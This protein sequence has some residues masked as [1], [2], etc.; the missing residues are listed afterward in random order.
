MKQRHQQRGFTLIEMMVGLGM[1]SVLAF[2]MASVSSSVLRDIAVEGRASNATQGLKGA[3]ELLS[4]EMRM[5]SSVSPYL[6]GTSAAAVTCSGAFNL[7]TTQL[8]FMVVQDESTASTSGLQPYY[9]GYRYDAATKRLLRGE[10]PGTT[11]SSC[12][13]PAGDPASSTYA[14]VLAEHIVQVDGDGDGTVDAAFT[15]SASTININLGVEIEGP[16]GVNLVQPVPISI[17]RR[18][19]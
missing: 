13:V 11:I 14:T 10:I 3:L 4:T 8:R 2:G 1:F 16:N 7:S 9:V 17:M 19:T 15:G 6:V 18:T 5:S 12:T